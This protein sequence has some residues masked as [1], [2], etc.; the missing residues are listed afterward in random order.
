VPVL[1][2]LHVSPSIAAALQ[3][4]GWTADD[5]MVKEALPTAARGHNLVVVAPPAPGYGVPALAGLMTRLGQSSLGLAL[6]PTPQLEEWG[7]LA[8]G[9]AENASLRVHV[10][11]GGGRTVRR[12][13][14]DSVN[15]LIASPE[16][17]LDFQRRSA[18]HLERVT[19]ILLAWPEQWQDES[20]LA[21]LMQ[22]LPREIQRLVLTALPSRTA[23]LVERYARRALTVGV[24]ATG[25]EPSPVGP[26]RS[27]SVP[28]GERSSAIPELLEL[29]DPGSAVIWTADHSAH[30][31][32][33]RVI[34]ESEPGI[35]LTSGDAPKADLIL[36]FDLPTARRL[37]Q[38]RQ[39]GDV[40]LLVPPGTE[41]YVSS[42]AAPV[43]PLRL[44]GL[45]DRVASEAG[46]RRRAIVQHLES[47]PPE[48]AL[49]TLAPLFE[50]YDP[51]S[52]AAALFELWIASAHEVPSSTPEVPAVAK[53]Y[54]GIG[55]RD[56]ATVNDLVAVL[57]KEVR[58]EREKVGRVELRDSYTLVE[59]PAQDA[60]R[61]ASMLSGKII[62]R[63]RVTARVD[64]GRPSRKSQVSG[65]KSQVS[66]R[67][68]TH[69]GT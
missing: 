5:P 28:W 24:A 61:V 10:T 25:P 46:A 56:G 3:R 27:V 6:C 43:R 36:A 17:A 31:A 60:E 59:I 32:I 2:S 67:K 39:A 9:L 41:P 35:Q 33:R 45:A 51:S 16:T 66:D 20:S 14:N 4:A 44:S 37:Q 26:V 18:L 15:L 8:N 29:L 38:L 21:P 63:K 65:R 48:R 34:A 30:A 64:R 19:G 68:P 55:K 57:T 22:D 12:L 42:I 40:V 54:V 13:R 49:L 23:D 69:P 58:V 50:R 62:R 53:I 7:A 47:A 52:I 1:E 11:H